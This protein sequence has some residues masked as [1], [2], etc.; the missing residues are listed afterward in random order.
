M[1]LNELGAHALVGPAS[2][3]VGHQEMYR[4]RVAPDGVWW[5]GIIRH[6]GELLLRRRRQHDRQDG[7]FS[8]DQLHLRRD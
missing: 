7:G 3:R 5:V 1:I 2:L 8:H 4:V 6:F